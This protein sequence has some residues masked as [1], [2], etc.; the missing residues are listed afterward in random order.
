[1]VP[2]V[3]IEAATKFGI[4]VARIP[5]NTSG[6]SLSCAE[7]AIYLILGLLRDQVGKY[8]YFLG[9]FYELKYH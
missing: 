1:M 7:H 2:G 9:Y 6:N 8:E 4:K 3:D 5:G